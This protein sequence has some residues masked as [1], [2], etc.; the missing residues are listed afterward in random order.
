MLDVLANDTFAPDTG[1]TLTVTA[2]TQPTTGGTVTL[3]G[4][5]VSFTPAAGFT[6][7]ATFTY[8]LSDGNGGTDTATVTVRVGLPPVNLPVASDDTFSVAEDSTDTVLDV[9]ANDT[10]DPATGG[11]L[12]VTAV[13]Q[14]ATGGTVT[15]TSSGTVTFTPTPNFNGTVTFTYTVEDAARGTDTA[16]VTVTVTPVND[17]P[18]ALDDSFTVPFNSEANVLNVLAN[19]SI[20]PDTGE[21]ITVTAV[22]SPAPSGTVTVATDGSGVLFTPAEGFAGNVT[23]EYTM[24]D[25]NGGTDT[26]TVS[27]LVVQSNDTDG[28]GIPDSVENGTT[29]LSPTDKDTD[30]DGLDDGDEDKNHNGTVD[31][32][33]TNPCNADTD[34]G[35]ANDGDEVASGSNPLDDTDD[36]LVVGSGCA[37]TGASLAPLLLL[38]GLPLLRRRRTGGVK[39]SPPGSGRCWACWPSS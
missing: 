1:E 19:D 17:V 39:A 27:V 6:G 20:A 29:C 14:P 34:S 13:T 21:T 4:G 38:L 30:D 12:R 25:G 11:T 33:E 9:L 3:T 28:D 31:S 15:L 5:V 26:A 10:A 18:V 22:T 32:G 35:G 37:S 23:F 7:I 36:F 16:T 24:S 8:T 2:V